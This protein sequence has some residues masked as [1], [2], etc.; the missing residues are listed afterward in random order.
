MKS[1][2]TEGFALPFAVALI[3]IFTIIF[4]SILTTTSF[5]IKQKQISIERMQLNLLSMTGLSKF[6]LNES[7]YLSACSELEGAEYTNDL[8]GDGFKRIQNSS[9]SDELLFYQCHKDE[10]GVPIKIDSC[11]VSKK[12]S[13]FVKCSMNLNEP[14]F[15]FKS[16][17]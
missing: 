11:A 12:F 16:M 7:P 14:N 6:Y 1:N 8:C 17:D 5:Y 10:N 4:G 3:A 15:S 13:I 2:L 9:E